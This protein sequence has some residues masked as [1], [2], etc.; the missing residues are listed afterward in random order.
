MK[1]KIR[2]A[3]AVTFI[4]GIIFAFLGVTFI[5]AGI[6]VSAQT[7]SFL[8]KS[9]QTEAVISQIEADHYKMNGKR[10]INYDVWVKYTV[11]GIQYEELLNY[12]SSSM[13]AGDI[14]TINYD[15]NDPSRILSSLGSTVIV[16]VFIPIGAVF[17]ILGSIFIIQKIISDSHRDKLIQNGERYTGV[18]T[19]VV[20]NNYVRINGRHPF[21]AECEVIDPYSGEKSLYCSDSIMNDISYLVGRAVTVYVDSNNKKK[22]YVDIDELINSGSNENISDYR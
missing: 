22:Y 11:E 2:N 17:S 15:P 6:I 20:L 8:N 9:E 14:I 12:Y 21:K 19:N 7:K 3:G 5:I 16:L 13:C 18:I 4:I 1:N 10:R